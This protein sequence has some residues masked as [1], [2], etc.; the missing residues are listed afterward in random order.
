MPASGRPDL[1]FTPEFY[2]S[3]RKQ[4]I[5]HITKLVQESVDECTR[6]QACLLALSQ[7][8]K[9]HEPDWEEAKSAAMAALRRARMNRSRLRKAIA[10]ARDTIRIKPH[11]AEAVTDDLREMLDLGSK[12]LDYLEAHGY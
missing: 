7:T 5:A 3:L 2:W 4:E 12:T 6:H 1:K 9:L 11:L 10:N 8:A